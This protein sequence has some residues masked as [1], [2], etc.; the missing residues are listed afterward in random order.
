MKIGIITQPLQNNY[1]CLLQNYA[2]QQVLIENGHEPI[3]LDWD[4][5]ELPLWRRT[6][7]AIKRRVVLKKIKLPDK[8]Y[9]PTKKE[10][11]IIH[12]YLSEF[13][14]NY[15]NCSKVLYT[16]KDFLKETKKNNLQALI[17]GSDQIWRPTYYV[18]NSL[19]EMF[20]SFAEDI[21]IK[22]VSYA[23]SFG[24]DYWEFTP[25]QTAVCGRLINK[26]DLVTVREESGIYL[27]KTFFNV[28]ATHVLDPTML[29]NKSVYEKIVSDNQT[30]RSKG[31]LFH[32]ILDPSPNKTDLVNSIASKAGLIPFSCMP[33]YQ[34]EN[35][36]KYNIKHEINKCVFPGV[37]VWLRC[38]MDA[39]M[40][41]CDSFHGCVFSIIFNKPFWLIVN[42]DRGNARF[43][44]LL[45]MFGLQDRL[46]TPTD[47]IDYSKPIDWSHVNS[48]L[49]NNRLS[50]INILLNS[51]C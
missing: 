24:V 37:D 25:E 45:N 9:N 31:N 44:S 32:Y 26:F 20:L 21:D 39:E 19:Y 33:T 47:K 1:G 3:T 41:I 40:V 51:L 34:I 17:V 14:A 4:T 50:S 5:K 35:R 6:L 28:E 48:I 10:F 49:S 15:I 13:V 36:T 12:R 16:S 2:L 8:P 23:A 38:F 11:K 27:C 22:R 43:V 30:P 46:I 29:P 7:S 18:G 42:E